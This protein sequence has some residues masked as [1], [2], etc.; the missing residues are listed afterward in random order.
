M[1]Y[2]IYGKEQCPNCI[3][4]KDLLESRDK[5]YVYFD[6]EDNQ[7]ARQFVLDSGK[8]NLPQVYKQI[9]N[10]VTEYLGT[11]QGLVADLLQK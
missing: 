6:V 2:I 5:E 9:S 1:L 11:Y 10:N 4:A 3:K 7:E 8:R